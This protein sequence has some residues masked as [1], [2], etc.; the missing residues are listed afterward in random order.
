MIKAIDASG[1]YSLTEA[2][3]I[4]TL[5][6]INES[7]NF[8]LQ[9]YIAA[10][11]PVDVTTENFY[12]E[13]A[14]LIDGD[15]YALYQP[16]M[17]TDNLLMVPYYTDQSPQFV[18]YK[19][20]TILVS[21]H[22]TGSFDTGQLS[23]TTIRV[24][25]SI[26]SA[27]VGATDQ[28]FPLRTDQSYP[29][30]TDDGV[31]LIIESHCWVSISDDNIV[32][33]DWVE[34]FGIFTE[35]FRYIKVKIEVDGCCD[36]AYIIIEN[37]LLYCDVPDIFF[38]IKGVSVA[39]TTGTDVTFSDYDVRLFNVIPVVTSSIVGSSVSAVPI[40]SSLSKTGFHIDVLNVSNTKIAG[41]VD[42]RVTG[43]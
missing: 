2:N 32:W 22:E 34:Y 36:L 3:Y 4:L 38:N 31:T 11:A 37:P 7:L 5:I 17:V 16:H 35:T 8:V 1:I 13:H 21:T 9:E 39:G 19:G 29:G 23:Q 26:N 40:I 14:T 12:K 24:Y 30:D 25:F 43:A 20:D 28:T 42:C 15:Y 6:G 18:N 41:T 10:D 27:L 33:G